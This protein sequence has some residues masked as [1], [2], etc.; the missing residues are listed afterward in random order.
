MEK[1]Y[2]E[3]GLEDFWKFKIIRSKKNE[4]GCS[5]TYE[6][7]KK[8]CYENN[9]IPNKRITFLRF[10]ETKGFEIVKSKKEPLYFKGM[11]IK[12]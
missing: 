4:I 6:K 12:W 5:E 8:W 7:Y 3:H 10:L 9:T 2:K 1:H 11:K